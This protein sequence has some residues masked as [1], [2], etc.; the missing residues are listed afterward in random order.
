MKNYSN[1]IK[2][3][4]NRPPSFLKL[5]GILSI[6]SSYSQQTYSGILNHTSGYFT[7][8]PYS[9]SYD[10]GSH[11]KIF[12]DGNNKLIKFWNSSSGT[13]YTSISV[14]SVN[15]NGHLLTSNPNNTSATAF[16]NWSNDIAR[17][18]IGGGGTGSSNGFDIQGPGDVSLL[19]ISGDGN[20]TSKGNIISKANI[21]ST[22]PSNSG[23][24]MSMSWLNNV[25]RIRIGGSGP[26]ASQGLDIQ[27]TGDN[28][29]IRIQGSGNVGIGTTAPDAK[30][31]VKGDIHAQE[32]KVDLNGAVA[33]DYVFKEDYDLRTLEETQN[34]IKEHGH[35]P[36][37]PSAK[38]MEENGV[39]LGAMNMKLLEKIEELT[40]YIIKQEEQLNSKNQK[41]KELKEQLLMQELH[42]KK[43]DKRIKKIEKILN[44]TKI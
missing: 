15:S 29:L 37:I 13:N 2:I 28:S 31:A 27:T 7:V 16:F 4:S 20:I 10:D 21:T 36:N 3:W 40:L 8:F 39:E 14:G 24:T 11:A 34:Y 5:L 17:I 1:K 41:T 32:V 22:N 35:L 12:Y 26:G 18:R 9:A 25:A 43:Q 42:L 44:R 23:A 38:E 6:F 19:R 30:L 33:P